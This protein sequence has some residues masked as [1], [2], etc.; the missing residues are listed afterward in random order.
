MAVQSD[1]GGK[2]DIKTQ[3]TTREGTYKLLNPPDHFRQNRVAYTNNQSST[4]V[5]ISLVTL[6]DPSGKVDNICFNFG[7]EL[8]VYVFNG[9]KKVCNL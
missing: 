8:Y 1:S 9:A 2:D 7:R 6:P 4:S 5:H 3:F